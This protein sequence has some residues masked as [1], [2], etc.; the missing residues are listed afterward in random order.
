MHLFSHSYLAQQKTLRRLQ[1]DDYKLHLWLRRQKQAYKH[2]IEAQHAT[3]ELSGSERITQ[4]QIERLES[5]GISLDTSKRQTSK[6]RTSTAA[7]TARAHQLAHVKMEKL[8]EQ[9]LEEKNQLEQ[10]VQQLQEKILDL[11]KQIYEPSNG[12]QLASSLYRESRQLEKR[13]NL[14]QR[15]LAAA[16]ENVKQRQIDCWT[17]E[18]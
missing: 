4:D 17:V 2:E 8:H 6:G 3:R 18:V 9:A 16:S 10:Q 1:Q 11:G 7:Q 13:L 5:L 12:K 14:K 15:E